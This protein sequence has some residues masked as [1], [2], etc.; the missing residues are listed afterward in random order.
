MTEI[1]VVSGRETVCSTKVT[2]SPTQVAAAAAAKGL[3]SAC[4]GPE[5]QVCV[6]DGV[7]FTTAVGLLEAILNSLA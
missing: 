2:Q 1:L 3:R 5:V 7:P 6:A 4:V